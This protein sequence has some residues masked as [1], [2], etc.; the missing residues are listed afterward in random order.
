MKYSIIMPAYNEEL[1]IKGT[2]TR[3]C[4]EFKN[5][6][7]IVVNNGSTD[8]TKKIVENMRKKYPQLKMLNFSIALGK[9]GAIKEG[10]KVANGSI[11]GFVDSDDAFDIRGV[12][13]II[14][15][16]EKNNY[17]FVIASKW[18]GK[19]FRE[20]DE[21]VL[22]KTFSRFWNIFV[23][24][25]FNLNIRD[26]QAGAKFM[27]NSVFKKISKNITCRGFEFDVELIWL[28]KKC[29]FSIKEVFVGSV[30]RER[31]TFKLKNMGTMLINTLKI[32]YRELKKILSIA[33]LNVLSLPIII[34][35]NILL[36]SQF[37]IFRYFKSGLETENYEIYQTY[38]K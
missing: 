6:E 9:G 4:K 19:K 8:N 29:G 21:P 5:T 3:Y 25:L 7:I 10:L 11:I 2:L 33:I 13:R 24:L 37:F 12:K 23:R 20:V 34:P 31:S 1:R 15:Y 18:K 38:K 30:H 35:F 27:K 32:R 26:T 16:I 22:R 36:F 14:N 17:D 28:I